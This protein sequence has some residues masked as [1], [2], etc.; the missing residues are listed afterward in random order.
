MLKLGE[1]RFATVEQR[2][3]I[4]DWWRDADWTQVSHYPNENSSKDRWAWEFLRRNSD[5]RQAFD[6]INREIKQLTREQSNDPGH[7]L[8]LRRQSIEEAWGIERFYPVAWLLNFPDGP[9]S[10]GQ[11]HF[12]DSDQD[13]DAPCSFS[14]S[15]I[16]PS[17][18]H[19]FKDAGEDGAWLIERRPDE[20]VLIFNIDRPL[21]PQ[22]K[23]AHELLKRAQSSRPNAEKERRPHYDFFSRYLRV[24]DGYQSMMQDGC[25]EAEAKNRVADRLSHESPDGN[26][27]YLQQVKNDLK[28]AKSFV[29]G[30]YLSIAALK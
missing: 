21:L 1:K 2:R 3:R 11:Y 12:H 30:G 16:T 25:S 14:S 20:R 23:R 10:D 27:D 26:G 15:R 4:R 7:P 9:D 19:F 22:I 13:Y 28:A 24:F 18:G 17:A 29:N 5:F 8:N 6:A